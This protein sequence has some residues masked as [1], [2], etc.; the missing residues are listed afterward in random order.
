[1][2][3]ALHLGILLLQALAVGMQLAVL[4]DEVSQV[5]LHDSIPGGQSQPLMVYDLRMK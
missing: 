4:V 5:A 3:A 2:E 1:M